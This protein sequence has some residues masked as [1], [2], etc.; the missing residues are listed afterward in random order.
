MSVIG[1]FHHLQ[2]TGIMDRMTSGHIHENLECSQCDEAPPAAAYRAHLVEKHSFSKHK[3]QDDYLKA[4][5][6]HSMCR[7]CWDKKRR[8]TSAV[9]HETLYRV[10]KTCCFCGKRHKSGINAYKNP[11]SNELI[12][13]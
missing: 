10:W 11:N 9:G 8:R 7:G 6:R 12:C 4:L 3:A 13:G 2:L 5:R 1:M